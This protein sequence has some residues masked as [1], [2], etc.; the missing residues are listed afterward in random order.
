MKASLIYVIYSLNNQITTNPEIVLKILLG[1]GDILEDIANKTIDYELSKFE[2]ELI[3][4]INQ[5]IKIY[6]MD[7]NI[8]L[9]ISKENNL[10]EIIKYLK[11]FEDNLPIYLKGFIKYNRQSNGKKFLIMKI[12]EY[13]QKINP[14]S[15]EKK[16]SLYQGYSL[17]GISSYK[18][19][20]KIHFNEFRN[21]QK[22]RI[23]NK[24]AK[25]ILE[26]SA[27]FLKEKDFDKFLERL[28]KE[29]LELSFY[30]PKVLDIFDN[31]DEY[32]NDLYNQ[33]LSYLSQYKRK[34]VFL[35]YGG[36]YSKNKPRVLWINFIKLLLLNLSEDDIN[37]DNIKIIFYFIVNLFNPN[38]DF[39]SLEFREDV[40]PKL[41]SQSISKT[42]ILNFQ[43]IY[44]IIDKDYS[45][46]YP[47]FEGKNNFTQTFINMIDEDLRNTFKETFS[48]MTT[49]E[50]LEIKNV[51]KLSKN[52]PF[53]LLQDYFS[54]LG[55]NFTY[56]SFNEDNLYNF[57]RNCFYNL[58]DGEKES[59]IGNI[60]NIEY[61]THLIKE[62]DIKSIIHDIN[63]INLIKNI[64]KSRVMR[65]AYIR[66]FHWYSTNGEF[67]IDEESFTE[68]KLELKCNL[69]N[70]K[71]IF[72]YYEEF[73]EELNNMNY[74]K[75]FI[76]MSLPESIKGFTFGYLKIVINSKGIKLE[77]DA[78]MSINQA[79]KMLLLKAYLVF[80][81]IQEL[82]HFIKRF[83]NKNKSF[84]LSIT[85]EINGCKEGGEQLIKLLFD[86][87]LIENSIN[88]K[89]AEYILN[90][91][92]WNKMSVCQ[93]KRD[94]K[95]IE[96]DC[97]DNK[98][99]IYLS[100]EKQILCDHSKLSA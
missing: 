65:D 68:K 59:F 8:Y 27:K 98:C 4:S 3:K 24:E 12:Y 14:Y 90:P 60:R 31:T 46:Y 73:C 50:Q 100:S 54:Q 66:I 6:Y 41:F 79:N 86:H 55:L 51:G 7:S 15:G 21:I 92:N 87:I 52:L 13:F 91:E 40:I 22:K 32:Y 35:T 84:N 11:G 63:F 81:I 61:P 71:S 89:Q 62:N 47:K 30:T 88:I 1:F 44:Q 80:L 28:E 75:L 2:S 76:I 38:I 45:E 29:N 26:L 82:N 36:I 16:T 95:N 48:E 39:S 96:T 64:M 33:L 10:K 67:D 83:L 43:E 42:E 56:N 99:L 17:Y 70:G 18:N 9:D 25:G 19:I 97:K 74:S 93:F 20:P 78:N 53:P 37:K 57:Y 69:I 58:E 72:D 77:N 49:F 85:T 5:L 34:E 94:F 23:N